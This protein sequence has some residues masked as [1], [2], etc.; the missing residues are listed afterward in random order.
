MTTSQLSQISPNCGA[1][2]NNHYS[3]IEFVLDFFNFGLSFNIYYGHEK[4]IESLTLKKPNP[5]Y[6][7][8]ALADIPTPSA[9]LTS[10]I[11]QFLT[12]GR[13]RLVAR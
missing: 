6:L 3:T 10:K 7:D 12:E 8:Q 1:V 2:S 4:T 9:C 11:L 5:H 13:S